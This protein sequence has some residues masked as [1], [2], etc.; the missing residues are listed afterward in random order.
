MSE[1]SGHYCIVMYKCNVNVSMTT[2][3]TGSP[4][5]CRLVSDVLGASLLV[6]GPQLRPRAPA[7]PVF[8]LELQ[9]GAAVSL[10]IEAALNFTSP[11]S[12]HSRDVIFSLGGRIKK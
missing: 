2:L 4:A 7:A 10:L 6:T 8:C 12:F 5:T 1:H 9:M 11:F 3:C